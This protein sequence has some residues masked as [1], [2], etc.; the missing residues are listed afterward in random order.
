MD[1]AR[2]VH[3]AMPHAASNEEQAGTQE[4]VVLVVDDNDD[5][6]DLV[7]HWI[8]ANGFRAVGASDGLEAVA[9]LSRGLRPVLIVLDLRMP[10][11]NGWEFLRWLK[12]QSELSAVPV[13]VTSAE[14]SRPPGVR[15]FM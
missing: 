12:R 15:Y 3:E 7:V 6:R 11:M 1:V 5:A 2:S 4:P 9:C 10:R 14:P 13:V 8:E